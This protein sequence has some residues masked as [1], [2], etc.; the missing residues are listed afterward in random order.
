MPWHE[1]YIDTEN[2]KKGH[3]KVPMADNSMKLYINH[4]QTFVFI[5]SNRVWKFQ[6]VSKE[7]ADNAPPPQLPPAPPPLPEKSL[8]QI[9]L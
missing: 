1:A 8:W 6:A 2:Q 9:D 3:R 7:F 5:L 4:P